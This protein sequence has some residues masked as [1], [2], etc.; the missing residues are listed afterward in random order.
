MK[1]KYYK[2]PFKNSSE[3]FWES[4]KEYTNLND[5]I[6]NAIDEIIDR[7]LFYPHSYFLLIFVILAFYLLISFTFLN[8]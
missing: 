3:D 2:Q 7:T 6:N 1:V 4:I 5:E 8:Y